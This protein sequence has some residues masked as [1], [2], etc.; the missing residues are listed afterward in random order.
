M[1]YF[2]FFS[3]SIAYLFFVAVYSQFKQMEGPGW[4]NQN[5]GKKKKNGLPLENWLPK[6]MKSEL[7]FRW[8]PAPKYYAYG[9][10]VCKGL[11]KFTGLLSLT[12]LFYLL[13]QIW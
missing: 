4:G 10:T 5:S 13:L 12:S 6:S 7:L 2:L 9:E 3:T 8:Q 11:A 1:I